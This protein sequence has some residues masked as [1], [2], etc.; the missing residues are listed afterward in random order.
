MRIARKL[1][2]LAM[3]A[4]AVT[5]LAAPPALA[6]T[7]PELHPFSRVV[8]VQEVHAAT[9]AMC[10]AVTPTPPAAMSPLVTAGGCRLH[11]TAPGMVLIAHLSAGGAEVVVS[12]CDLEFD[13]RIDSSG[14][15]WISHQEFTQGVMGTCSRRACGQVAPP[16]SEGR[17][18]SYYLQELEIAG[19]GPSESMV[20]LICTEDLTTPVT[21][22]CEVILPMSQPTLHRNRFTAVSAIGHGASFP[23]CEWTGTLDQEAVLE[24]TG[25][26]QLEQNV[27][28][29]HT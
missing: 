25:E 3:L 28:I 9:D 29:R 17:A 19:Q 18:W 10:P 22:H 6:Q 2:L 16:T 11:Y 23:R 14:E 12:N 13:M 15:G 7:E 5:A 8:A 4:I 21:T 24:N 1:T 27:E 26:G 20:V